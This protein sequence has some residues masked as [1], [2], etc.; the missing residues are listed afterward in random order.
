MS[1]NNNWGI[2]QKKILDVAKQ[3]PPNKLLDKNGNQELYKVPIYA[4]K[5]KTALEVFEIDVG[6]VNYNF[7]NVRIGK[8]KKKYCIKNKI[9]ELNPSDPKHQQIVQTILLNTK[10]Y[11]QTKVSDLKEDL[12]KVGQEEPALIT[13]FG[14]LWN[15]NRRT[16]QMRELFKEPKKI[17]ESPLKLNKI[18]VCFLPN[19][20]EDPDLR[21]LEKRLQQDK[22]TKESYGLVSEMWKIQSEL[23]DFEFET[24]MTTPTN[25]EKID[26]MASISSSDYNT[27]PKILD[28]KKTIGLMDEYLLFAEKLYK[29]PMEGDY[30]IIEENKD[31]TWFT[32]LNTLLE[33]Y[34]I[35]YYDNNPEKGNSV[36]MEEKWKMKCFVA[37]S[38][39]SAKNYEDMRKLWNTFKDAKGTGEA[40]DTT[41]V[42][43]SLETE[44]PIISDW[45]PNSISGDPNEPIEKLILLSNETR[46]V[47]GTETA[48]KDI[49]QESFITNTRKMKQIAIN[50]V[51]LLAHVEEDLKIILN[52]KEH[53]P[54]N[55]KKLKQKVDNCKQSLTEIENH[56]NQ[57]Q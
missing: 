31:V 38:S 20:L 7:Q 17:R 53:I 35:P 12:V 32:D 30:E 19:E 23:E 9:N 24:D 44:S 37:Y 15:G 41:D 54:K 6:L 50:P 26:L 36:D 10:S 46:I 25:K 16:S 57:T 5:P 1:E 14:T 11:S 29:K 51:V 3:D 21:A 49:E 42:L 43:E 47:D 55:D 8:Y 33:K 18:K 34:V 48:V 52:R 22:E 27:W 13:Q 28:A 4:G 56:S 2:T 40:S 39:D 45:D